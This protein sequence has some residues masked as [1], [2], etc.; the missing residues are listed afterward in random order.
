MQPDSLGN[1]EPDSGAA[2]KRVATPS[3]QP[4]QLVWR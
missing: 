2:G 3:I 4:L 1:E